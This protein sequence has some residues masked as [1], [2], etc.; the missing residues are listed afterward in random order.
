MGRWCWACPA[1]VGPGATGPFRAPCRSRRPHHA[2]GRAAEAGHAGRPSAAAA[3][4]YPAG[5]ARS[6]P[7][8][9]PPSQA[10][11]RRLR[12]ERTHRGG[13]SLLSARCPPA[14][15]AELPWPCPP[16]EVGRPHHS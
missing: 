3:P 5:L 11:A 7:L 2:A 6:P 14:P 4:R 1:C 10:A 9:L 12:T 13:P 8:R 15:R 16:R